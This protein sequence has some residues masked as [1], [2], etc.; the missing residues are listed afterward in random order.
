VRR[1]AVADDA[2]DVAHG[3]RRLLDQ[4]LRSGPHAARQQVLAERGLPELGVGARQLPR[5]AG[6]RPRDVLE[7][8]RAA[9]VARDRHAREQIQPATLLE[10]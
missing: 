4:E 2:R 10:R 8:E 7:R 6:E 5:R 9:V 1:L 3:D